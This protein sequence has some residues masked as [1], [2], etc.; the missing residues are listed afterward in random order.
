LR[1]GFW[2]IVFM[3]HLP[4]KMSSKIDITIYVPEVEVRYL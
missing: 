3:V 2:A 1:A 4:V